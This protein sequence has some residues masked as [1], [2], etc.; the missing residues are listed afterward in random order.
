MAD[1]DLRPLTL[2]E[3]LD[4]TF[5]LY[6][7]HFWL[8]VGIMC[9]PMIVLLAIQI[10]IVLLGLGAVVAAKAGSIGTG[11]AVGMAAGAFFGFLIMMVAYLAMYCAAEAATVFAVSDLYLGKTPTIRDSY[12]KVRQKFLRAVGTMFLT[13]LIVMAGVI[14]LFVPGFILLARTG[15]A[16]PV[17]MLED[18]N[19]S[20]AISRSMEL[21]KGFGWSVFAIFVLTWI[22][23]IIALL[24]FQYPA[25]FITILTAKDHASPFLLLAFQDLTQFI[26]STLVGPIGT[27]ALSL[28][29]YN[30][31]VQKEGFDLQHMMT[32]MG[33]APPSSMET[34]PAP[35]AV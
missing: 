21:T 27:I 2:G 10:A 33:S 9:L 19:P 32:T 11:A 6:K 8:F 15:V 3:V 25:T 28:M 30:L 1:V 13:G 34:P 4:R 14:A 16:V 7:K 20:S 31:R 35:S 24:V 23:S 12:R 18:E 17:A 29:Y 22:I 5:S 26:S